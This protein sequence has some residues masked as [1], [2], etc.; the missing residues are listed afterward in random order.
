MRFSGKYF[1]IGLLAGIAITLVT[2]QMAAKQQGEDLILR[3]VPT[4]SARQI[5]QPSSEGLS[6]P[7]VP[8]VAKAGPHAYDDWALTALDGKIVRLGDLKG[9]VVFLTLS[10]TYC[11]PCIAELPWIE[12]LAE[13]LHGQPVSFLLVMNE[14]QATIREFLKKRPVSVP[15]YRRGEIAPAPFEVS[16][17]PRTYILDPNGAVVYQ[18]LGAAKWSDESVR[19]YLMA[20]ARTRS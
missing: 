16:G 20:L 18:H 2:L 17:V 6:A 1:A 19:D 8:A 15:V 3:S 14:D 5:A 11:M 10:G 7:W 4:Y 13:S 12:E 9:K